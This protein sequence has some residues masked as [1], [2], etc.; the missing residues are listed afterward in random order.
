[1]AKTTELLV[2]QSVL[3]RLSTTD[4][5]PVTRAQS[6]SFLRDSIKRNLEWLLN[7][8]R[9]P[10]V[11][12]ED[13]PLARQ[14]VLYYGLLDLSSLNLRSSAGQSRLQQVIGEMIEHSE[15][16]L[17]EVQVRFEEGDRQRKRLLFHIRARMQM[18]PLPEEIVFDTVLDL[19]TGEYR[20]D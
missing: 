15:P 10:V 11:G 7:T 18:K 12:I 13:Y 4:D 20:V 19:T 3:D 2:A 9:P 14:T 1:M 16:R 5:W 17:R 6:I 8:R